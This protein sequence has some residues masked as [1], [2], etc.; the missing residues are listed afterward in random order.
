MSTAEPEGSAA[1]VGGF[2][3]PS[4]WLDVSKDE[5]SEHR[6]L[7]KMDIFIRVRIRTFGHGIS[8]AV[9]IRLIVG[10]PY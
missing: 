6:R 1:T 9:R 5:V 2:D 4:G 7:I 3:D 10:Q 8:W